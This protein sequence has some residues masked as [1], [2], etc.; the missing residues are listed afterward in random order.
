MLLSPLIALH[1][2]MDVYVCDVLVSMYVYVCM[3]M[4]MIYCM[5]VTYS[6]VCPSALEESC[7]TH[8]LAR[9]CIGMA[10]AP[11]GRWENGT[12]VTTVVN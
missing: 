10:L 2:M 7:P 5:S 6:F 8:L 9:T 3:Y 1:G 11:P 4:Y 12:S